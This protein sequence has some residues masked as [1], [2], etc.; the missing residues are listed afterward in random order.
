MLQV[1]YIVCRALTVS[2]LVYARQPN[3][4]VRPQLLVLIRLERTRRI[5]VVT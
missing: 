2:C 4:G 5:G 1:R 3:H